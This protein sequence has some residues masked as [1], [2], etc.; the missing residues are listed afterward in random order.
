ARPEPER[1]LQPEELIAWVVVELEQAPEREAER[2]LVER[3]RPLEVGHAL[4]EMVH[5]VPGVAHEPGSTTTRSAPV[6]L[7]DATR[8]ASSASSIGKRCVTSASTNV[9]VD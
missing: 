2:L 7:S 8:N 4:P 3:A 9:G 5:H 1:R 6:L